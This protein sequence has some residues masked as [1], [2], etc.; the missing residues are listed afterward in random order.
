MTQF[1]NVPTDLKLA[2]CWYAEKPDFGPDWRL[3]FTIKFLFPK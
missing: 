2:A 1:G 3:Q